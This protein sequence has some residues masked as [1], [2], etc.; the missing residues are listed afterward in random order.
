MKLQLISSKQREGDFGVIETEN[1]WRKKR[2]KA[3][4]ELNKQEEIGMLEEREGDQGS[5][6]ALETKLLLRVWRATSTGKG[7]VFRRQLAAGGVAKNNAMTQKAM[8]STVRQ[9]C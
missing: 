8:Q 7:V 4:G 1:F 3:V 6:D 2:P 9:S 5:Q